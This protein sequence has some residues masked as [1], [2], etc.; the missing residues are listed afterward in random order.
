MGNYFE[1]PFR[2]KLLSEQVSNPNI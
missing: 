2:G 1:I